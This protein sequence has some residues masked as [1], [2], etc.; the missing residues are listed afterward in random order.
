MLGY[1]HS[2]QNEWQGSEQGYRERIQ[3]ERK[4]METVLLKRKPKDVHRQKD[5]MGKEGPGRD[6]KGGPGGSQ[7]QEDETLVITKYV[8]HV[9]L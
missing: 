5:Q 1:L 2:Q 4:G 6:G 9:A 3:Q 7:A 8:T